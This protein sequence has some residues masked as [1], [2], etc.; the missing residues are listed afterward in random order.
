MEE[1][2]ASIGELKQRIRALISESERL[3]LKFAETFPRFVAEMNRSLENSS[4]K[5]A[6]VGRGSG[7]EESLRELFDQTGALIHDSA[8]QF[9]TMRDRDETLLASL[10]SGISTLGNLD[11]IIARIKVDSVEME[12]V[13]LNAMTVALKSGTAGKAFSVITDELKRLSSRTISLT[14]QLTE[15]GKRLLGIFQSYREEVERLEQLQRE[16][17]QGL[18]QRLQK[19]FSELEADV[20]ST[21]SK[22]TDLAGRSRMIEKP[23]RDIMETVQLQDIVRQSLDHV[24]M[25][26]EEIDSVTSSDADDLTFRSRLTDLSIAMVADVRKGVADAAEKFRIGSEAVT[27][28][29][30]DGERRRRE[31]LAGTSGLV[32][33]ASDLGSFKRASEMLESLAGQVDAYMR[34]KRSLASNGNTLTGAVESLE[35]G[36]MDFGKILSRFKN[37]DVASRIEVAKQVALRS[38]GETV[39]EM[40]SLTERIGSDVAEATQTTQGFIADTRAAIGGYAEMAESETTMIDQ[41]ENRLREARDSL[42]G[43]KASLGESVSEFSLFTKDFISL[44]NSSARDAAAFEHLLGEL[45]SS[46][47]ELEGYKRFNDSKLAELSVAPSLE[48]DNSQRFKEVIDRFTIYAHKQV[49]AELG[50]FRVEAGSELGEVT[51]F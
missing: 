13:S 38:M 11:S 1:T 32:E 50:G 39:L 6:R 18:E 27:G 3:F 37:I 12:L 19:S 34:T 26:L 48:G 29:V 35:R 31:L 16:L 51:L 28:V 44:V 43:I 21:S 17:F 4:A 46:V 45:S 47:A 14:D 42:S 23:I 49:A 36:F 22:M 25:A 8:A 30:E 41:A 15:N 9:R 33:A 24:L 5:L 7:F 40:S 10:N 20:R 2:A